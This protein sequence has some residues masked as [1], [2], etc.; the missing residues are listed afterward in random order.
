[1]RPIWIVWNWNTPSK[2]R[3]VGTRFYGAA[4]LVLQLTTMPSCFPMPCWRPVK[5]RKLVAEK[6]EPSAEVA[7]LR[8]R[9]GAMD[10]VRIVPLLALTLDA[11]E[12]KN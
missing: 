11:F 5:N 9:V 3:D 2:G 12:A 8:A 7:S 10:M 1:M 6:A 4:C